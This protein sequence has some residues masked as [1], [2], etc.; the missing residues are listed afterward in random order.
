MAGVGSAPGERRGGRKKGTPNKVD[1]DIKAA[2]REHGPA[3]VAALIKLT[4]SK[5]E[6]VQLKSLQICLDRGY[7]KATQHIEAEISVYDRLSLEEKEALLELLDALDVDQ[8]GTSGRPA[9][10]HH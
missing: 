6:N 8:K 7:G 1:K 3:L 5:D 4:K 2:F 10:T 9:P